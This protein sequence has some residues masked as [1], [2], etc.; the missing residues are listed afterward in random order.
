M[1]EAVRA[2]LVD[3]HTIPKEVDNTEETMEKSEESEKNRK[4]KKMT[5]PKQSEY[6][7]VRF[8]FSFPF[9]PFKKVFFGKLENWKITV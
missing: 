4:R 6:S 8:V 2:G 3:P 5:K 1:E 9:I 7:V